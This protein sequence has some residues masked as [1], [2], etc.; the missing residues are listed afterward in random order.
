[1]T[2]PNCG[3]EQNIPTEIVLLNRA[4][5]ALDQ[6]D[7]LIDLF[8]QVMIRYSLEQHLDMSGKLEADAMLERMK[9]D[10]REIVNDISMFLKNAR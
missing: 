7:K 9:K 5:N 4:V 8:Y 1:M 10:R 2:C 3:Q 6:D